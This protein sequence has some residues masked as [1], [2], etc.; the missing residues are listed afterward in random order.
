MQVGANPPFMNRQ[1]SLDAWW[2]L[3]AHIK[4]I[5]S[6]T[7]KLPYNL[8]TTLAVNSGPGRGVY[9]TLQAVGDGHDAM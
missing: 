7:D 2:S 3:T 4:Q 1:T 6:R 5:D 9:V 8:G